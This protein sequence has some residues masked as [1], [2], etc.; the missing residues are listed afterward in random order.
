VDNVYD[1][2]VDNDMMNVSNDK[3]DYVSGVYGNNDYDNINDCGE[4]DQ[5]D[6]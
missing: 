3:V 1:D 4:G 2:D 6:K 5:N